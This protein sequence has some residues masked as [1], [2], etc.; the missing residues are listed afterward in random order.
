MDYNGV[1]K[2]LYRLANYERV[3]G[4]VKDIGRFRELLSAMGNPHTSLSNPVLV[5][6]TKGKGS[7]VH[8]VA[9][10][11]TNAG[12][13]TGMNISPHLTS[14]HERIQVDGE[15]ISEG[16]LTEVLDEVFN[17]VDR[18]YSTTFFEAITAAAFLHFLRKGTD[19]EVFEVGLGGR[20]DATNVVSQR[21]GVITRIDYDHTSILGETLEEIA[22]EKAGIVKGGSVVLTPTSNAPVLPVIEERARREGAEL[23][24]VKHRT[25]HVGEDGTVFETDGRVVRVPVLGEFQAENGALAYHVLK[26]LGLPFDP[27]GLFVPGRMHVLRREPLLLLDGA[28]NRVSAESLVSSLKRIFPGRRFNFV[29]AF[30]RGKDYR[31]FISTVR[32]VANWI[33]IT[34]YP[35]RRSLVPEEPYRVCLT[36]HPKCDTLDTFALHNVLH[37]DT[38]ITGSLYLLGHFL[39]GYLHPPFRV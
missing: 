35:W 38:V 17:V 7:V 20:L 19:Y 34:H 31:S 21:V 9:R 10:A 23:I 36:L 29:L 18:R 11:L 24:V 39:R 13:R 14:L 6:G 2:R 30:S 27:S 32:E 33:F 4:F 5:A 12:K 15:P 1:L 22:R 3:R 37:E 16:D 28:H 8:A 26:V 25:L